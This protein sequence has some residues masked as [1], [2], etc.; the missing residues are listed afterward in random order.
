MHKLPSSLGCD[1]PQAG[2]ATSRRLSEGLPFSSGADLF[3]LFFLSQQ[4]WKAAMPRVTPFYAV[5]CYPEPGI[6]KMLNAMGTGFDCASKGEIEVMLKQ[7]VHPSR[8]V[9]AHPCKRPLDI[10]FAKEHGVQYT[11][12]D[13]ESEL[14]KMAAQNPD[15]K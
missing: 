3:P 10:K 8:I 15:F 4:A 9:F 7:G 2:L 11:T 5:K 12:F 13:T 1:I 14:H 6:L